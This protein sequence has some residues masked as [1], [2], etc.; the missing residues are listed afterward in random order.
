MRETLESLRLV[1]DYDGFAHMALVQLD[2]LFE[3]D[4][5]KRNTLRSLE[6]VLEEMDGLDWPAPPAPA[7]GGAVP[8]DPDG[9]PRPIAE[10]AFG[11]L[12][13]P[14]R[15][16]RGAGRATGSR[17]LPLLPGHGDGRSFPPGRI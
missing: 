14:R 7:L 2:L 12:P 1:Q 3:R 5:A 15:P 13:S 9:S 16:P 11:D 4:L 8:R 10:I 6:Q 17:P